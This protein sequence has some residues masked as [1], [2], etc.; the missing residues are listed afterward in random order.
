M[1]ISSLLG[2][3][4]GACALTL[5]HETVRRQNKYAPRMDKL[6]MEALAKGL[7]KSD[8]KVPPEKELF[9]WTMAGDILS[10]ALYYS[11]AGL[12]KQKGVL[13]RSIALGIAGG[14]GGMLLPKPLGL[15]E[16]PSNRTTQTKLMTVGWYLFGGLV[17]GSI[18]K[19]LNNK[20]E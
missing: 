20:S 5:L 3:L 8:Q 19:A 12:G 7:K 14:L 16:K 1:K 10:N 13:S 11:I 6:G 4:A 18:M 15:N 9:Y 17:A 2:G